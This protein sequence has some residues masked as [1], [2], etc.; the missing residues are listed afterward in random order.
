M[1]PKFGNPSLSKVRIFTY[2]IEI[3]IYARKKYFNTNCEQNAKYIL[4]SIVFGEPQ[5]KL[6]F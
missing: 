6:L 4:W 2:Q 3:L 5:K 1:C